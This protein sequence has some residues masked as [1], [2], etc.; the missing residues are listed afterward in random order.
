MRDAIVLGRA[1][2]LEMQPFSYGLN[3]DVMNP[4]IAHLDYLTPNLEVDE[5]ALLDFEAP[6]VW[7]SAAVIPELATARQ[8]A[9]LEAETLLAARMQHLRDGEY[10]LVPLDIDP[11]STAARAVKAKEKYGENSLEYKTARTSL[12]VDCQ[13]LFAEAWRKNSWE[14]FEPL[15][16]QFDTAR[17]CYT[18]MGR[19]LSEM[20]A[21]GVTPLAEPEENTIRL[22]EFVEER[23]A[24]AAQRLGAV[25]LKKVIGGKALAEQ[26]AT[27]DLTVNTINECPDWAIENYKADKMDMLGGYNPEKE[28]MMIRSMRIENG[29]RYQEQLAIPVKHLKRYITREVI[30]ETMRRMGVID[31]AHQPTK[32]EVRATQM[33]NFNGEGV[34]DIIK[35][36]DDVASELSGKTIFLGDQVSADHPRDYAAI[37]AEAGERQEKLKTDSNALAEKLIELEEHKTDHFVASGIV[38]MFVTNRLLQK[39]KNDVEQAEIVFDRKTADGIREYQTLLAQGDLIQA[40][41]IWGNVEA[42]APPASFCGA[43]SCGLESESALSKDGQKAVEL[44]LKAT[45]GKVIRDTERACPDCKKKALHYDDNASKVCTNCNKK[46][47]KTK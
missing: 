29:V 9:M 23:T 14:Y 6:L 16:Q 33:I 28:T 11:L 42:V 12:E 19:S 35:K 36:L 17:D 40:H 4:A 20:V 46:D 5:I 22:H 44:G 45:D 2:Q 21:D 38:S 31:T 8:N 15:E 37:P 27:P 18:Y 13:R 3:S 41:F 24:V 10:D 25:S 30:V 26:S 7:M 1:P 43:G 32:T 39:V 34:L 47:I